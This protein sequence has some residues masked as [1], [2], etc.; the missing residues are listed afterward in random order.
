MA[1]GDDAVT[2]VGISSYAN[3]SG[4]VE[5]CQSAFHTTTSAGP[6]V[7]RLVRHWSTLSFTSTTSV[8]S[9]SPTLANE[10]SPKLLPV[11]VSSVPPAAVPALGDTEVT[12]GASPVVTKAMGL[13]SKTN[14]GATAAS[15]DTVLTLPPGSAVTAYCTSLVCPSDA[16]PVSALKLKAPV[17]QSMWSGCP[18]S[19]PRSRRV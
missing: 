4:R 2:V 19:S 8:Q 18:P 3:A 10:L 13:P 16:V 7:W 14:S 15:D 9:S 1:V 6:A 11:M 17:V 12:V 5:L